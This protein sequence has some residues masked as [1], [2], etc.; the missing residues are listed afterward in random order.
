MLFGLLIVWSVRQL[1]VFTPALFQVAISRGLNGIGLAL[2]VPSIQSLVADSTDDG[3]RGSAFGWLQLASCIGLIS[4]G[5]VGLL[6][7]QTT[8]LGIA[9]WRIAFHLVAVI[10]VAVGAL[11]W[12][13]SVDPHFP[14][15]DVAAPGPGGGDEKP[16][17][18]QVVEEMFAEAKFVVR[19][20]TFQIFVAQGVSGSFPWSALS[21]ASMWLELIGFSHR[22]TAVLMTIFWVASSLGGLI[23][24]KMGD[25]LARR[26]P[27]AGRIVLSQISAGSAVPLAAV[28][29]LGLPDDPSTGIVHGVVLFVM[30]VFISWN[31]P[32]TN[33]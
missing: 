31:G 22:G 20:P 6:L 26:Y 29:L 25:A 24:G 11:N 3:T 10:S 17:A 7:A 19:I 23:G 2:V 13:F 12:F 9:G 14:A 32:A 15:G 30:G 21:F 1:E 4:G 27:D 16:G 5:F 18:R 8:V 33:L 28:L